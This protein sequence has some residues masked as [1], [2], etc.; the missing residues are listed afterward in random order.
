MAT[1]CAAFVGSPPSAAAAKN[2]DAAS[3]SSGE[4]DKYTFVQACAL[5]TMMMFGTG[6]YITIP[7]CIAATKPPG[8]HALVGY[9]LAAIG[10]F[11]DSFI[12]AELG[13]RMPLSGGSY[14]YLRECYGAGRWG[15]LAGFIYLWQFW[16]SGPAE[17]A[18]GFIAI[19]DYLVFIH[20]RADYWTKSLTALGLTITCTLVLLRRVSASGVVVNV[21]WAVTLGSMGFVIVAG[22]LHFDRTNFQLPPQPW[23][24]PT[25]GGFGTFILSLGTACRF[26]VYD[27]TGYY[28]V[29]QMGGEVR[30]PRS[31]IPKSCIITCG[32][33]LVIYIATYVAVIGALPWYGESGFVARVLSSDDSAAYVMGTFGEVLFGRAVAIALVVVVVC[34]IFGSLFAMMAGMIYLPGAAADTCGASPRSYRPLGC[35]ATPCHDSFPCMPLSQRLTPPPIPAGAFSLASSRGDQRSGA[36]AIGRWRA[37]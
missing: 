11:A 8:P 21:L 2:H 6:P 14:I 36:R 7:Y 18:S 3:S 28:D 24:E 22:F 17:I 4:E 20:G 12:W 30:A 26:G 9:S 32:L 31:T 37:F 10:C 16:V 29:C 5:N 13:S 23:G 1:R 27:F 19:S 34:V 35:L 33:V 25:A 15:D